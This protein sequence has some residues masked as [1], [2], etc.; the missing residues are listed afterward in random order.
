MSS[1]H[2]ILFH[3]VYPYSLTL[4]H[5]VPQFRWLSRLHLFRS[6]VCNFILI[7]PSLHAKFRLCRRQV[8]TV[9][10]Y[11]KPRTNSVFPSDI[12]KSCK[13]V[14][15]NQMDIEYIPH[16]CRK[17]KCSSH[18]IKILPDSL[19]LLKRRRRPQVFARGIHEKVCMQL[20]AHGKPTQATKFSEE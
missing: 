12:I 7:L 3:K 15:G 1:P 19:A 10:V 16:P 11:Y 2:M 4:F 14:T 6:I 8:R 13:V 5:S 9:Q 17:P 20:F 18:S